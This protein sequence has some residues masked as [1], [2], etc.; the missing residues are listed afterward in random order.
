MIPQQG[1]VNSNGDLGSD[2]FRVVVADGISESGLTPLS[3]DSRFQ[4]IHV[5]GGTEWGEDPKELETADGLL[6]RSKTQVTPE[7]LDRAPNLKVIGRAGVGVDNVD[8]EAATARGIPVLNAP[9][10]NT[11]SAVELTMA[12][13]L[14][15]ARG[16]P[17]ADENLRGGTW[18]KTKGVELRGKT[19]GLIGAGRIG[20]G[21]ATRSKAFGMNVIVYDPYLSEDRAD[22]LGV[23]I[24]TLD[25]VISGGDVISLHVPLTDATRGM[26]DTERLRQMKKTALLVNVSRGGVVNEADLASALAAGE[27]AGAALDVYAEEPLP[28]GSALR[29]AP[30]IVLTP[31]L[32][33]STVEAQERVAV[34]IA[35]GVRMAILEGDLSRAL[36]AP[37]VGGAAL[38]QLRPLLSLGE[39]LGRLACVLAPGPVRSVDVRYGGGADNGLRPLAQSVLA[40]LLREIVGPNG[41]NYVNAASLA[42]TRG[43]AVNRSQTAPHRGYD[44]FL[45]VAIESDGG[46][47]RVAGALLAPEHA[48]L[49][50]IDDY[51]I[52]VRP[53]GTLL[54]LR[55]RDVPGVIGRVGTLLG[56]QGLN[57]AE[58]HQARLDRGGQALA[59]VSVDGD[60][61]PEIRERLLELSEISD[62]RVVGLN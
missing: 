46:P 27:I 33:A 32:G 55:N 4:L 51:T 22:R 57:I 10:G 41:V 47:L 36:N 26:I 29:D 11:V 60:V 15:A 43:I 19:L 44:E 34:E 39:R 61:G 7:L 18:K 25:E 24:V 5:P 50:Q 56:A 14:A 17:T 6:V 37:A 21:V 59:T 48:R 16:V 40:G 3:E 53:E 52:N 35:E 12:L 49:V 9:A 1:I 8:L 45:E 42:E 54:I 62:A 2:T 13:I 23:R 20:G 38:K 58:Y 30:N 28:E 31:H